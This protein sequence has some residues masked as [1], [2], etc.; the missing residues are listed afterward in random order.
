MRHP[1]FVR[2]NG[3]IEKDLP[4]FSFSRSFGSF[5]GPLRRSIDYSGIGRKTFLVDRLPNGALPSYDHTN[6]EVC[7]STRK[8]R[9]NLLM[10]NSRGKITKHRAGFVSMPKFEIVE[11]PMI[12][13]SDIKERRFKLIH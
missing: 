12:K 5:A 1:I 3:K 8:F 7:Q 9:H 2:S 4:I 6:N 11:F 13:L 10:V